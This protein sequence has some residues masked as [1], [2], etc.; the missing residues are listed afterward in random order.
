MWKVYKSGIVTILYMLPVIQFQG[1]EELTQKVFFTS[2]CVSGL[3]NI[4]FWDR[5]WNYGSIVLVRT[6]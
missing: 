3:S 4:Y 6:I 2:M 1:Q 5:F